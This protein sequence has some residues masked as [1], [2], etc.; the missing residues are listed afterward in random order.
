MDH[1][2]KYDGDNDNEGDDNDYVVEMRYKKPANI[3]PI[4]V[5][6]TVNESINLWLCRV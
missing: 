1:A 4:F 6:N 2:S 5:I 3:A